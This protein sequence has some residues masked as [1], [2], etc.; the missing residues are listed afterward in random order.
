MS[1]IIGVVIVAA[2]LIAWACCR[3]AGSTPEQD[4]IAYQRWK[5]KSGW[6][7]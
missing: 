4:K 3:A 5:E 7:D 2:G 6:K 1:I